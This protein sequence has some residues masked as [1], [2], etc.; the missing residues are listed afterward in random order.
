MIRM[1]LLFLFAAALVLPGQSLA[2]DPLA[3]WQPKFDPRGAEHTYLLSC[4][5]HPAI[6]GVRVG[7][8]IRDRVWDET[9]GRLYVDFRPM[10]QLGGEMDVQG[11]LRMGAI[12]GMMSSSVAAPNVS[13]RLGLVNLPFLVGSFDQLE[14]FR[15]DTELF[16]EYGAEALRSGIRVVDYTTYGG[17]GWATRTPV[18][19]LADAGTVVFRIAEAP[20]N[21]DMYRAWGLQFTVMPWPDVPQALQTGVITGMDHTPT[22]CSTGNFFNHAKYYTEIDYAQGLYIHLVNERWLQRL[23]ADL[24]EVLLRVIAEESTTARKLGEEQHNREIAKAKA[25]GVTFN[26]LPPADVAVMK[27]K[28]EPIIQQWEDRIGADFLQRVRQRL[29]D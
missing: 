29:S 11:K 15:N 22:V 3:D 4:V 17:Y 18:N 23:P 7:F 12:H 9:A 21:I 14:R 13:P 20:V 27:E 26:R 2:N 24:R 25:A 10:S 16:E 1:F 6:E 5:G 19:S 8:R 28:A